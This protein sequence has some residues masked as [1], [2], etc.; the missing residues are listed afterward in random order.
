MIGTGLTVDPASPTKV[1]PQITIDGMAAVSVNAMGDNL[2]A[3][4]PPNV[5]AGGTPIV[6]QM[7]V[8][9]PYGGIAA[10]F[11]VQCM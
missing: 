6:R 5:G 3:K 9:N 2:V 11:S 10:D 1:A 4:A 8:L 7:R